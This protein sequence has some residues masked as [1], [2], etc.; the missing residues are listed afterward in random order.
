GSQDLVLIGAKKADKLVGGI[1]NDR[2]YGKLGKDALTGGTGQD[3]FVFDTKPNT[4]T[5]LDKITDFNVADDT[6]WLENSYFKVGNGTLSKPKQMASKYFYKGTK[7]HDKDD[8]II[9]D[10]KKGILYYDADGTGS[11]AQIKIAAL[12]Q[13]L[14]KMSYKD[15][16]VI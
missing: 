8:H 11:S 6:I 4:K 15:F 7:A 2:L 1:G 16:F 3:I 13:N 9:Y 12:S 10:A 14:S 5:N